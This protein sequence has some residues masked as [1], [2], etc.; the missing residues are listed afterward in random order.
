MQGGPQKLNG[1]GKDF[2]AQ[3]ANQ[4]NGEPTDKW[5]S[6]TQAFDPGF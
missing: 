3:E 6:Q 5:T 1:A 2:G 4:V